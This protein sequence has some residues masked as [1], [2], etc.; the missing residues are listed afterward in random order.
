MR[1]CTE[2][3]I[4]TFDFEEAYVGEIR[5]ELGSFYMLLDNV[6]ILESNSCNRDVRTMRTNGM[7]VRLP[8]AQILA[9]IEEGCKIYNADGVLQQ[10]VADQTIAPEEYADLFRALEGAVLYG[11]K[12]ENMVYQIGID[13][14][15]HAYTIQVQGSADRESWDRFMNLS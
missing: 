13:G 14:E 5:F 1:F 2:N 11:L 8:E 4:E 3:E 9:V 12:K 6:K 10:E 15:D 7:E